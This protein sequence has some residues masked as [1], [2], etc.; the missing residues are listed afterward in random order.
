[1]WRCRR[2]TGSEQAALLQDGLQDACL[3]LPSW[4]QKPRVIPMLFSVEGRGMAPS[5]AALNCVQC[6]H[7]ALQR[8]QCPGRRAHEHQ[9]YRAAHTDDL[10]PSMER[11]LEPFEGCQVSQVSTQRPQRNMR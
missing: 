8:F 11:L 4:S 5:A 2:H 6:A 3:Q 1:M 10:L 9:T 7:A